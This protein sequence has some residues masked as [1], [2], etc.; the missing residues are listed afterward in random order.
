MVT[1]NQINK[2]QTLF[3]SRANIC[4]AFE[5]ISCT[6][7]DCQLLVRFANGSTQPLVSGKERIKNLLEQLLFATELEISQVLSEQDTPSTD[8]PTDGD[9]PSTDEPTDG[10]TPSTDEPSN[11]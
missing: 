6:V 1:T 2:L 11:E 7:L 3:I 10:D 8:E 5:N 4:K 9:T